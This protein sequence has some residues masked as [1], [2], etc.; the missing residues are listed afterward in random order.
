MIKIERLK[1]CT[2]VALF[3]VSIILCH[4][5]MTGISFNMNF[6]FKESKIDKSMEYNIGDYISPERFLINYS[7]TNHKVVYHGN[8]YKLW[9]LIQKELTVFLENKDT[10]IENSGEMSNEMQDQIYSQKSL[11]VKFDMELDTKFIGEVLG[12][13]TKLYSDKIKKIDRIYFNLGIERGLILAN[14]QKFIYVKNRN[15]RIDKLYDVIEEIQ[16]D[17]NIPKYYNGNDVFFIGEEKRDV[18]LPLSIRNQMRNPYVNEYMSEQKYQETAT[19]FLNKD[20]NY[21]RKIVRDDDT[22]LYMYG[23]ENLLISK[24]GIIEYYGEIKNLSLE[25]D[26]FKSFELA[27]EFIR[28]KSKYNSTVYLKNIQEIEDGKNLGYRFSYSYN[29][30][31]K[32]VKLSVNQEDLYPIVVEVFGKNITKYKSYMKNMGGYSSSFDIIPPNIIIEKMYT[33]IQ[34]SNDDMSKN[35]GEDF[36]RNIN[37]IYFQYYDLIDKNPISMLQAAWV[38]EIGDDIYIYNAKTGDLIEKKIV[39]EIQN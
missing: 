14:S 8:D 20:I 17:E 29:V 38:I 32:P 13:D 27:T 15:N 28:S 33:D 30:N 36:L 5:I 7:K 2:L 23:H 1:T 9:S 21:I 6:I 24:S 31:D 26:L 22:I 19:K 11:V 4:D 35:K 25:R 16:L 39:E 34:N 10:V 37:N 18:F 12:I 3:I